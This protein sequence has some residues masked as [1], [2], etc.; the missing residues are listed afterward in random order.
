MNFFLFGYALAVVGFFYLFRHGFGSVVLFFYIR[1]EF[2][3]LVKADLGLSHHVLYFF[4]SV[5]YFFLFLGHYLLPPNLRGIVS[6]SMYQTS[7]FIMSIAN[8]TPSG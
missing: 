6:L 2:V 3:K 5:V 4:G 1:L 8:E 7:R